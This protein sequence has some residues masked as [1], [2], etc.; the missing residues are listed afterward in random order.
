MKKM[1]NKPQT[2]VLDLQGANLMLTVSEGQGNGDPTTPPPS[3]APKIG[4]IID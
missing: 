3:H 1:Y 2:D 4:D